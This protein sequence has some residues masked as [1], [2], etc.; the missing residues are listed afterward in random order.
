M[1]PRSRGWLTFLAAIL[2]V[3]LILSFATG[4]PQSRTRVPYQPFFVNQL[5]TNNVKQITSREDSLEG[6][7]NKTVKYDPPGDTKPEDVTRFKTQIPAFIDR[8]SLTKL[9]GQ[10]HVVVNAQAP[11]T[12]RGF[13]PSLILGFAPALLIIGFFVW[14]AR[15]QAGGGAGGV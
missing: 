11:D 8:A 10:L 5:T 9:L 15:R 3:N 6:E 14:L 12:G 7:L 4:G 2:V 13:L 1:I